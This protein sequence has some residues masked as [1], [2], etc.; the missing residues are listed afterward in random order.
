MI[1]KKIQRNNRRFLKCPV[2]NEVWHSA[3][4]IN[5]IELYRNCWACDKKAWEEDRLSDYVFEERELEAIKL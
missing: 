4:D 1:G 3:F 5:Y 2:C